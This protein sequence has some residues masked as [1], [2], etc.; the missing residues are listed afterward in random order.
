MLNNNPRHFQQKVEVFFK[1]II[2]NGT[3]ENTE[4]YAIRIEFQE[5]GSP[6]A[7]SVIW[8]LNAPNIENKAAYK[9]LIEKTISQLPGYLNDP[10]LFDVV[11]N[12]CGYFTEKTIVAKPLDSKF[13]NDEK[14]GMKREKFIT[15]A[16][17]KRY[18]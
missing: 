13:S 18:R 17:Q 1:E 6:H 2:L 7:H 3:L 9:E 5:K 8:I 10:E 14:L 12:E 11:K 16:S 4:Y 15:K